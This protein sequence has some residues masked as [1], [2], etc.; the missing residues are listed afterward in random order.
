MKK[1]DPNREGRQV[2][3]SQLR[4]IYLFYKT[5]SIYLFFVLFCL[6]FYALELCRLSLNE[7][8]LKNTFCTYHDK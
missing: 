8:V 5:Y 3:L 7:K 4:E 1:M 2:R 6:F